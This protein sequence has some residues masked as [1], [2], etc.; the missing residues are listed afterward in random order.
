MNSYFLP[1]TYDGAVKARP[2]SDSFGVG[3]SGYAGY[4]RFMQEY[5][6]RGVDL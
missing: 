6:N 5:P 4:S 2:A 3:L 1:E